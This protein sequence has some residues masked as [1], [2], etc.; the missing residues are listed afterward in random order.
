MGNPVS[1]LIVD[2]DPGTLQTLNYVLTEMGYEVETAKDGF[3]AIELIK[4]RP[5]D[6]ISTD[7]KMPGMNGIDLLKEINRLTPE[8]TTLVMTAYATDELEQEAKRE[9]A[10][11][12]LPKP[13]DLDKVI[14]FIEE[15]SAQKSK[16]ILDDD[17]NFCKSFQNILNEK[18]YD[19]AFA[20]ETDKAIDLLLESKHHV[21]FLDM[22]LNRVTG[23]DALAAIK[24]VDPAVI[25]ILITGYREEMA[26]QIE[27][28]LKKSA[29]TCLYKPLDI[30]VLLKLLKDMEKEELQQILE[31]R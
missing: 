12:V 16:L 1:A 26:G 7:M 15:F 21:I 9:G 10:L 19:T 20:T 3:A 17:L 8:T 27:E 24:K 23:L 11:A 4:E 22:K 25:I 31:G 14:S 28:C 5:F 13:L 6:V 30:D 18:G 2:D 29:H